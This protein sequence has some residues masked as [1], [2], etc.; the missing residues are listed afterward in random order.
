MRSLRVGLG[1]LAFLLF[2]VGCQVETAVA[3]LPT[4]AAVAQVP[5]IL[6]PTFTPPPET[7]VPSV[8]PIIPQAT[9]LPTNTPLPIPTNTPITPTPTVTAT[10]TPDPN[11][12][13]TATPVV[14]PVDQYRYDEIIPVEAYPVPSG[15]NGWGMH[16]IPTTTQ[17]RGVVDRFVNEMVRMHIKWVVFL[18]DNGN[19]NGNDYLVERLVANG[20]MPVMRLYLSTVEPYRDVGEI[21][22]HY[23]AKGVYYFQIYNEPNTNVENGQGFANP[24]SYALAWAQTARQVVS[25]GGLPGIGAFSPGGEYNHY[26]FLD[27]TLR[28]LIYN[29]DGAL[30]NHAWLSVHNYHGLRPYDDPDG[31][32]LYRRYN[33][34]VTAILGRSLPIIGTEGGSYHP[35]PQVE[36]QYI[37]WQYTY[38]RDEREPYF[39]AYSNWL[40]AN[41]DGGGHDDTWEWQ[42]LFR[43]GWVHPAVTDFFYQ[44][45]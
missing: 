10:P 12:D 27:R 26:D 15:N 34:I 6:P 17:E 25:S 2:G 35:D 42:T 22:R 5:A 1:L 24:N 41:Q 18:N 19:V 8:T 38:M 28:A 32:W 7:A 14:K 11:A 36:K 40:L 37:T 44:S 30:L 23:R 31:F 39:L 45:N 20:I 3:V 9:S 4:R 33:D 43:P 16:W 13:A 29:G 21:V